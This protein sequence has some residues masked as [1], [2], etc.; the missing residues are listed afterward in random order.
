MSVLVVGVSHHT[1]PVSTLERLTLDEAAI[2][3][4]HRLA[5]DTAHVG[6]ALVVSTCNRIEMYVSV[7]RFHGSVDDVSTLL[8]DQADMAR[9]DIVSNLYVH[10]D[11]AAVAHLFAVASGLDSMVVGESQILGQVRVALQRGQELG[12]VGT[13]LNVLFQQA[14]RVGK[15]GHAETGIDQAGPSVVSSALDR[16]ESTTSA[17]ADA[18]VLV[19]GAGAMS[20]LTV[21][22]ASRR[23]AR[24]IVVV[25]RTADRAERLAESVG[26]RAAALADLPTELAN[27]DIVVS[28]TGATGTVIGV[29][30]VTDALARRGTERPYVIVDLALPRDVEEG[31]AALPGVT[32]IGLAELAE[33]LADAP[34]AEDVAGVRGIVKDEVS[35]FLSA[36]NAARVTP[37]VVALRT[38]A[39]EV[40]DAE[41]ERLAARRSDL[42]AETFRELSQTVRRVA[43]KLL[44]APTVRIKELA[45]QPDG[46]TYADAL[47]ELFSLDQAAVDAVTRVDLQTEDGDPR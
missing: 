46:L 1:A 19:V 10:Y 18:R 9:E 35:A 27:A 39:T 33:S 28:G 41:L 25:N 17:L 3:K 40:V 5:I 4:L 14:L 2:A 6:E 29:D 11:D 42:D 34:V 22:I 15:R 36:R 21:A 31:V 24:E 16:V 26:G 8:A 47:A 20:G 23:G 32:V 38:M 37:T 7:D 12:T 43:D 45:G 30:D 13:E 44:H